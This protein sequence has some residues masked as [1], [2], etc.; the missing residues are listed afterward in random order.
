MT[1]MTALLVPV[2][3]PALL[4]AR[5]GDV[6][7]ASGGDCPYRQIELAPRWDHG[8]PLAPFN[9]RFYLSPGNFDEGE[10]SAAAPCLD[11]PGQQCIRVTTG[12]GGDGWSDY[13]THVLYLDPGGQL[14]RLEAV[15]E[16]QGWGL[17][18]RRHSEVTGRYS[19]T[20]RR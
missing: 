2:L 6:Y 11:A 4:A 5:I 12:R 13:T 19:C 3:A 17:D 14:S 18:G 15:S 8:D 16:H 20:V 1:M 9:V 10:A 7:Q